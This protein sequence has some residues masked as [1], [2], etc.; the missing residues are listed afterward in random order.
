MLDFVAMNKGSIRHGAISSK[1]QL[2]YR[3]QHQIRMKWGPQRQETEPLPSD[4]DPNF[5]YGLKLE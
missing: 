4:V 3:N 5:A 1:D 2:E